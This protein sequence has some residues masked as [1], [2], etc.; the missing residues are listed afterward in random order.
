M[1]NNLI[2]HSLRSFRRQRS[3]IIINVLGLSIGIACSLLISL[4]VINELSFDRFNTKKER[5]YRLVMNFKMSGQEFTG[6]WSSPIMGPTM[7]KEFPEVEDFLRMTISDFEPV[8]VEYNKQ[9]Y[10]E[11]HLIQADSSFLNFFSIPLLKGDPR[12]LLNAPRELVISE[13]TAKKIFG[14]EDPVNKT[15]KIGEDSVLYTVS[16]VMADIPDNA[17]FEANIISSFMT[18][19][20]SK[21]QIWSNNN[22]STYLLLK[23]NSKITDIEKKMIDL[24]MVHAGEEIKQ[25]M[26][27]SMSEFLAKG[28]KYGYFFQNLKSIHLDP[29]IKQEFKEAGDPKYLKILGSLAVIILI[30]AAINFMNLSTA[31]ASRRSKEVGIKKIGGSSRWM[32][33]TQFLTESYILSVISLIF[34]IVLVK[35]TLPYL[36]NL[37]GTNLVFK[38]FDYSYTLPF[39]IIFSIIVGFLSGSYPA[40]YIS[41][42]NPYEV[43]KGGVRKSRQNGILR[44]ILVV[45]QFTVSILLITGTMVM[46]RQIKYMLDKDL[47]F[48]KEQLLVISKINKLGTKVKAFKEDL[49]EIP[50]VINIVCSSSVPGQNNNNNGYTIEGRKDETA[51]MWTNYIDYDFLETY[52]MS[53]VSG[54]TFSN[55]YSTDRHA[56]IINES[57]VKKYGITDLEKTRIIEPGDTSQVNYMKIIGV[58]KNFNSESL[59]SQ[60]QPYIFRLDNGE[61]PYGYLTVKVSAQNYSKTIADIE[62][63]WKEFT[64]NKP[65]DYYFLDEGLKR[66]YVKEKQNVEMAV[67]F[68][69]L[70]IFIAALGLFG[71]TSYTVEQRTKE[72]GVR[73][74]MGSSITG[75]YFEIS[76][77]IIILVS[78]SSLIALPIIYYIAGRWLENFYYRINLGILTFIGGF[79]ISLVVA[80]LTISYRVHRAATANPA[81]SLKYE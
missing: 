39:L 10:Q 54:R 28:N 11:A 38:L 65:L 22:V 46:F 70:A 64:I 72:I 21:E 49:K 56:C 41:S 48:K 66:M 59:H 58:V 67:I 43:L 30:I 79:A 36:N 50:G 76:K 3:Y 1:L 29:S 62:K 14:N 53:L 44:R 42:F 4:F 9:A 8:E 69:I 32:L 6:S 37:L 40:L 35:I 73:K 78:I 57:A 33:I 26:G 24:I 5:I 47:G 7:V 52:G 60:V 13:S 81:Q 80:V 71:L 15:L 45:F 27:I 51:L 61:W 77:E 12:N 31:Q 25:Y 34:G 19:P 18:S 17:H 20:R 74:A 16:G 63:K 55:S 68:S 75:I 23:P 2:R